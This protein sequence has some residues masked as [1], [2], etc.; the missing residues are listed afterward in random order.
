[1]ISDPKGSDEL[2]FELTL[3]PL[4]AAQLQSHFGCLTESLTED[5]LTITLSHGVARLLHHNWKK[6]LKQKPL[7]LSSNTTKTQ[8]IIKS[9]KQNKNATKDKPKKTLELEQNAPKSEL[10][11]I[12]DLEMAKALS[13]QEYYESLASDALNADCPSQRYVAKALFST[14]LKQDQLYQRY[15][16]VD[17]SFLDTIFESNK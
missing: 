12:M 16:G 1:M 7:N 15:P 6:S 14:K 8:S 3:D 10:Q 17:Q 11:E 13:R 9:N 2:K 4:L 5:D